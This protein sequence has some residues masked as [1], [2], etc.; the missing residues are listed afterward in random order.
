MKCIALILLSLLLIPSVSAAEAHLKLLALVEENGNS[1]GMLA[2]LSLETQPGSGRVFLETFPLTK[3]ATQIS[4]RLAKQVVCN[5]LDHDCDDTDFFFTI[6]AA[7]G[8]VGGPSAGGA[9]AVLVA[10]LL[11]G[12]KLNE[13]VAMTGTINSGGIIGP[14]GGTKEKITA[15]ATNGL[16]K[17][18]IPAGTSH[19]RDGN[20]TTDLIAYGKTLGVEIVEVATIQEALEQFTNKPLVQ[21]TLKFTIDETYKTT[22]RAVAEELCD[23]PRTD[24]PKI[25]NLTL[26]S[27]T[28]FAQGEYYSAASYCFRAN[29]AQSQ[30]EF[31][32]IN[33]ITEFREQAA[34]LIQDIDAQDNALKARPLQTITDVQT[35]MMVKERIDEAREAAE[36]LLNESPDDETTRDLAYATERANSAKAWTRFFG[37]GGKATTFTNETLLRS[38][39]EKLSEAEERYNYVQTFYPEGLQATLKTLKHAENELKDGNPVVCL[40]EAAK[41][42]AEADLLITVTGVEENQTQALIDLKLSIA[43]RSLARSQSKN[44]FPLIGYSYYEYAKALRNE[45]QY[46]SLLFA[47][48]A[49]ELSNLDIYFE[50][51]S[52]RRQMPWDRVGLVF[53]GV[54]LGLLIAWFMRPAKKRK[55]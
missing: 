47:E 4:M 49:T 30:K 54:I 7:P 46:S 48:Y 24:D 42:K 27:D 3:I 21:S 5:E 28:Y 37:T 10:T 25:L 14:V 15:A 2:D 22:M 45:D 38:C 34:K 41:A 50:Q 20:E 36:L 18:L 11:E 33:D 12:R 35:F 43:Q 31:S 16:T 13:S 1:T 6:N 40:H 55:R 53:G 44:I 9:A 23:K 39:Q 19:Y 29:L 17:I 8:I 32:K 51:K 52:P 26:L